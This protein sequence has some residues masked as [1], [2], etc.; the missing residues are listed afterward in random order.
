MPLRERSG[1]WYIRF[2][3]DGKRYEETT[4][5][6]ATSRNRRKAEEIELDY[7]RALEEGRRPR[8]RVIVRGFNDAAQQ[9][10]SWAEAHYREHPNSFKRIKTSLAS[11][12]DFFASK[13][14]SLIDEGQIEQYKMWRAIEHR[15]RQI[16][17]RHDLHA[18]S[19]F[20]QH[21]IKQGWTQANPILHVDIPSDANAT[22]MHIVTPEEKELYFQ[23][24]AKMPDLH[25]ATLVML[26]QGMRPEE[27]TSLAKTDVNFETGQISIRRGKSVNSRRVLDMTSETRLILGRR[28][29]GNSIW[30]FPSKRKKAEHVVR[31]NSAHDRLVLKA[32]GEGITIDWV[33]YDFRHT[34][35]TIAAQGGMD[36]KTL[37]D[38]LGHGSL[39]SVHK[40]IHPT[41]AH[42][43]TAMEHY[44]QVLRGAY[45]VAE[46]GR[47][48]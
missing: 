22:R 17:I 3:L 4:G 8:R 12:K 15:V 24:A 27:V 39:R 32:A 43:K 37:A 30:L 1:R 45:D 47:P 29:Q 14:V 48:N 9:F 7:R 28:M 42:K 19:T 2:R 23:R 21:S 5:L 20:F 18:L 44:E 10:L 25:D 26:N 36:L 35:A 11:A 33:I 38:L 41:A 13:P 6:A 34:F 40:Y 31:L 46:A 16:T